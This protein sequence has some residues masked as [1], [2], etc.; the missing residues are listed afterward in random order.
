MTSERNEN[1]E[2]IAVQVSDRWKT[3]SLSWISCSTDASLLLRSRRL[4]IRWRDDISILATHSPVHSSN[5]C[6]SRSRARICSL[7]RDPNNT[8]MWSYY[9]G[10]HTGVAIGI[11]VAGRHSANRRVAQVRYDSHL[12][13]GSGSSAG[14][15]GR[16]R[17]KSCPRSNKPGSTKPK[18]AFFH[19]NSLFRRD[20][21]T[22]VGCMVSS[23]DEALLR[24][25]LKKIKP[26]VS[27]IQVR[28]IRSRRSTERLGPDR[29][30]R[31][32]SAPRS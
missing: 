21:G 15:C 29:L 18:C 8:L 16:S 14:Q 10:G 23:A 22:R 28:S 31:M 13:I 20:Q 3:G 19:A 24:L 30:R 9:A 6:F 32:T 5:P 1:D 25:L 17:K 12:S 7:T 2:A 27:L 4:M 11:R 26:R